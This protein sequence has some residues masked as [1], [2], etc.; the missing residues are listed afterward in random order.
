MPVCGV[1]LL[2][3]VCMITSVVVEWHALSTHRSGVILLEFVISRQG[4]SDNYPQSFN[5]PLHA[6]VE[7][8]VIEQRPGWLHIKLSN[9]QDTW[10]PDY[11]AEL[12]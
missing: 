6:G 12:I 10:V 9:D 11:S 5:E 2:L 4:D 3:F 8:D 1:M 7:F